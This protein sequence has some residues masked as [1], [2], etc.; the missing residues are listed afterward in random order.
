MLDCACCS[1]CPL[2]HAHSCFASDRNNR[3]NCLSL[4][5]ACHYC[6]CIYCHPYT[7]Q[8][9]CQSTLHLCVT[10]DWLRSWKYLYLV[11]PWP[12]L[13]TSLFKNDNPTFERN[14][15]VQRLNSDF[16]NTRMSHACKTQLVKSSFHHAN[17]WS[18]QK[19]S[20]LGLANLAQKWYDIMDPKTMRL[21]VPHLCL[22]SLA[23]LSS[24]GAAERAAKQ[25]QQAATHCALCDILQ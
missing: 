7:E 22:S 12:H 11:V 10:S 4:P 3:Q 15:N 1:A 2:Q 18:G 9:T 24:A 17:A 5:A 25:L 20:Q 13:L 23:A 6:N 16:E 14:S 8:L 19:A 21:T